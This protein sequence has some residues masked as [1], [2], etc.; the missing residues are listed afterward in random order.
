[1]SVTSV[2]KVA[3][4]FGEL[5]HEVQKKIYK[6]NKVVHTELLSGCQCGDGGWLK[7]GDDH[8]LF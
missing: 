1:M 6:R 4:V 8:V 3:P 5:I 7:V 2:W